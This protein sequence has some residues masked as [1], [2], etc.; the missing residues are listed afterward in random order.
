[1]TRSGLAWLGAMALTLAPKLALATASA[2][3]YTGTTYGYGRYEARVKFAPGEGVISSFFMW[4]DGSEKAGT[5]W[6]EL[7]FEKV[8]GDCHLESNPL[9]GNPSAV[10]PLRHGSDAMA[11]DTFHVYTYEWT[12]EYISWQLDG[13]ELRRET[14]ATAQAYADNAAAAGMQIHFNIWPGDAT[15]GGT[16]SPAIVP[17]H[18]YVDWIQFSAYAGGTFT[19][20]WRED[21]NGPTLP[22]NWM[23]GS[24]GSPKNLSTHD[25][26][27]VNIVGGCA[28]LSLTADDATGPAGAVPCEAGGS[29]AGGT[30]AGGSTGVGGAAGGSAATGGGAGPGG[31]ATSAGTTSASGSAGAPAPSASSSIGACSL[32][33]PRDSRPVW[34]AFGLLAFAVGFRRSSARRSTRG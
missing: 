7:D 9:F 26:R 4:K 19:L 32:A 12:P 1:M 20:S 11:C 30:S 16:F 29:S 28:V 2:E 22:T 27:N 15:F 3:L 14:G 34:A 10:H 24:W 33:A 18:Q 8:G 21:F 23:T 13:V 5:F 17:V 31:A 25:S 6:N